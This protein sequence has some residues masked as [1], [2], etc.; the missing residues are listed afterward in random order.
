MKPIRVMSSRKRAIQLGYKI[1]QSPSTTFDYEYEPEWFEDPFVSE[2]ISDIDDIIEVNGV[3]LKHKVFGYITPKELSG[4]SKTLILIYK[5]GLEPFEMIKASNMGPNCYKYL[6]R[7]VQEID[8]TLLFNYTIP[9]EYYPLKFKI[10][11]SGLISDDPITIM[12]EK[13]KYRDEI[14]S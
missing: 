9:I 6:M 7:I 14:D 1:L 4:G 2:I 11:D 10:L 8:V 3:S 13:E 12:L 5:G